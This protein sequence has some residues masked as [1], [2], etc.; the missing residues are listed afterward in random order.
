MI[1]R[2]YEYVDVARVVDYLSN[3]DSGVGQELTQKIK[4][5]SEAEASGGIN[6]YGL[7]LGGRRKSGGETE[8]EQTVRIHAQH[9]FSRLYKALE[10]SIKAIDLDEAIRLE[11]L[12]KSAVVE[13]T[14]D[15]RRSPVN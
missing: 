13:V 11:E 7:N 6:I 4:A 2:D 14:R 12:P 8:T 15:F 1:L 10:G 5:G 3:I 9:M